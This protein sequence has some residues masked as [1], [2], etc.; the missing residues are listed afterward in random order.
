[1]RNYGMLWE[2][3]GNVREG[4]EKYGKLWEGNEMY[5]KKWGK[6]GNV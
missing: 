4:I 3:I 6:Y 5:E 1:M 2:I